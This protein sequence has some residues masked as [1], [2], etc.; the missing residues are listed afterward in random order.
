MLD[1]RMLTVGIDAYTITD[2][3]IRLAKGI[4]EHKNVYVRSR[5]RR[6]TQGRNGGG[7]G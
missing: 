6:D 4:T 1:M 3:C 5:P 7:R 2:Q